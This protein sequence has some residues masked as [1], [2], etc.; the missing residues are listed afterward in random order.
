M[1]FACPNC[2]QRLEA[3]SA[4]AGRQINCPTCS[5]AIAVPGDVPQEKPNVPTVVPRRNRKVPIYAT[6]A[7]S[8]A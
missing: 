5:A 4:W 6:A 2:G 7:P 1:K 8:A 3:E